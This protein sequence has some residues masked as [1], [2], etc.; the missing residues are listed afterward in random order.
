[1]QSQY[2]VEPSVIVHAHSILEQNILDNENL[3]S[4]LL[5][6][7]GNELPT[8]ATGAEVRYIAGA[9]AI[10]PSVRSNPSRG[11]GGER[12]NPWPQAP[13]D[14]KGLIDQHGNRKPAFG[15]VSQIYQSTRQI[16]P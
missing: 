1:V 5:W 4:I 2:L 3:P 15:V 6:S 8:P 14:Q 10:A 16:A 7:I 9:A 12:V 11:D 13:W